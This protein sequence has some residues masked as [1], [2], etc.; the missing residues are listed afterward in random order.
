MKLIA[1][2]NE[3]YIADWETNTGEVN[4]RTLDVEMCEE[5]CSCANAFVQFELSD[6]T[7]YV[8]TIKDDKA[9]IPP[10]E[11]AQFVKIGVYSTDIDGDI[12]VKRYSPRPVSVFVPAG[13]YK[14]GGAEAPTP[15]AG[16]FEELLATINEVDEKTIKTLDRANVWE[17]EA[18]VYFVVNSFCYAT[19]DPP[20]NTNTI[21][22][23]GNKGV[24]LVA[25]NNKNNGTRYF[26][27][28]ANGKIYFGNSVYNGFF[29]EGSMTL[30]N[31]NI[32]KS[33]T[34]ES[35]EE[36]PTAKAV[37]DFGLANFTPI[38]N[39]LTNKENVSNKVTC[40]DADHTDNQYPTA[41]A[42]Y[43]F[44]GRIIQEVE[45]MLENININASQLTAE[46]ITTFS[47]NTSA[48][49]N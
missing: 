44:G 27:L 24:L 28:F 5:L 19:P 20:I 38:I 43:D 41:K 11:K 33:I 48:G 23:N 36:I 31:A 10:F 22:L 3:C 37:Y 6:G 16:T 26:C 12:C 18:G 34:K 1:D 17:L 49:V 7:I 4:A 15:T 45:E 21:T 39:S 42:V 30:A 9:D 47:M 32:T 40:I 2:I 8:S 14:D 29:A 25:E 35:G 46:A 13:S